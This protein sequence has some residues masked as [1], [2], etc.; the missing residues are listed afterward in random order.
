M[1]YLNSLVGVNKLIVMDLYYK[2]FT[3]ATYNSKVWSSDNSQ[4]GLFDDLVTAILQ[5]LC[6]RMELG[7]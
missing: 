6:R 4:K 3:G 2:N 5:L 1:Y 7:S